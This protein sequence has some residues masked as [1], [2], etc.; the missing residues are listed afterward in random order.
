[1]NIGE[2]FY[3][4]KCMKEVENEYKCPYCDS[5]L[6]WDGV[7]LKCSNSNCSS[8]SYFDLK[9]WCEVIGETDNF[10]WLLMEQYLAKFNII[11]IE[12]L[13]NKKDEILDWFKTNDLSITDSK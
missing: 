7:D 11:S 1:M 13:Y 10:A 5:D 9:Q 2:K 4:S 8:M 12:S 6:V 3:C